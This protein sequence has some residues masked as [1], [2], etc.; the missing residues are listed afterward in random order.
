M[1]K[2]KLLVS[3]CF[4]HQGFKYDGTDNINEDIIKLQDKYDFVLICPEVMGGLSVP[5]RPAEGKDGRVYLNDGTDVTDNFVKGA[6]IAKELA[7][8]HNIKKALLK[9]KSPSC[10]YKKIYD[11]SFSHIVI[12]GNGVATKML[13]ELGI[14]IYTEDDI[15]LL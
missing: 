8:N 10:G 2:E 12:E 13:L 5:R 7:I 14:S 4:L 11:G 1:G 15:R 3:A 9:A 6:K